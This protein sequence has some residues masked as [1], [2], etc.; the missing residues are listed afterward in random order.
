MTKRRSSEPLD[1]V[2]VADGSSGRS[3]DAGRAR[4][5]AVRAGGDPAAQIVAESL[6]D[7]AKLFKLIEDVVLGAGRRFTAEDVRQRTGVDRDLARAMW[8]A[9]GFPLVPD[10][11]AAY[12]EAD[13]EAL[14]ETGSPAVDRRPR[15]GGPGAPGPGDQPGHG[16]GGR[17][18]HRRPEPG[19]PDRDRGRPA[20]A[21]PLRRR[22][23]PRA[24]P[25]VRLPVPAPPGRRRPARR[26]RGLAGGRRRRAGGG[27]L[28]RPERLHPG[29][30]RGEQGGADGHRRRLSFRRRRRRRHRRRPG[31]QVD[32]RR[33]HVHRPLTG[34]GRRDRPGPGRDRR[35]RRGVA[36]GAR[37]RGHRAGAQPPGRRVRLHRQPGQPAGR[38]LAPRPGADQRGVGRR[39]PGRRPL[40]RAPVA[41]PAV[42]TRRPRARL[43][44]DP[45]LGR[46]P[47]GRGG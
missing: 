34:G 47:G 27:G 45:R 4:S 17:R 26:H 7:E 38:R 23:A 16:D 1:P 8:V 46:R 30:E 33:G 44:P 12:T 29:G 18:P 2:P 36:P 31:G 25:A 39:S 6:D 9:M 14:E 19:R 41:R 22:G 37:R 5:D 35:T 3:E 13:V 15:P 43:H 20:V 10:D 21:G 11:E 28:R 24:R 40:P 32:R 42:E